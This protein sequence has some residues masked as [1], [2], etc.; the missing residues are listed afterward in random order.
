MVEAYPFGL[1]PGSYA[2]KLH[3]ACGSGD[4]GTA[5]QLCRAS[6]PARIIESV[7]APDIDLYTPLHRAAEHGYPEICA[8]LIDHGVLGCQQR[9][10]R[11]EV[12]LRAV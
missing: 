3:T 7:D 6:N 1:L 10:G 2:S 5:E 4:R 11:A 9:V 12:Q 8:L